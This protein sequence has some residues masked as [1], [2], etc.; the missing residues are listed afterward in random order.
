MRVVFK[1][2]F[3][4]G[5]KNP[6]VDFCPSNAAHYP[7]T[8]MKGIY[9]YG[10]KVEI[11]GVG[12]KFVPQYVGTGNLY[13]CLYKRHYCTN[14]N[15]GNSLKG[16]FYLSKKMSYSELNYL[17]KECQKFDEYL[18]IKGKNDFLE[19]FAN[20]DNLIWYRYRPFFKYKLGINTDYFDNRIDKFCSGGKEKLLNN[21][22]GQNITVMNGG[23]FDMLLN[24]VN[25]NHKLN[26]ESLREKIISTK[27]VYSEKFYYLYADY[28]DIINSINN[29]DFIIKYLESIYK[30]KS[31]DLNEW[32]NEGTKLI[33]RAE[34]ATK[35]ALQQINIY[36]T[37]KAIK[38]IISMKI[39]FSNIYKELVNLNSIDTNSCYLDEHNDFKSKLLIEVG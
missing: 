25:N 2:P 39:D 32:K 22:K 18:G 14:R 28:E 27:K 17:Y 31:I 1:H 21:V 3:V 30:T 13:D 12:E 9:I 34:Y 20:L 29:D 5:S 16:L 19:V 11:E 10:V 37:A 23:D 33:E 26:I 4:P 35:T 24:Y 7:P 36:T 8:E 15:E 38:P 6:F